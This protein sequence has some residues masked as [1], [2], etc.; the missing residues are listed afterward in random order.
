MRVFTDVLRDIQ[1]GSLVDELTEA[2]AEIVAH[3]K[4]TGKKGEIAI[5]LTVKKAKGHE[6]VMSLDAD[7]K[8]KVPAFER[9]STT[10]FATQANALVSEN[11][12]QKKLAFKDVKNPAGTVREITDPATGEVRQVA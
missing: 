9:P 10:F 12:E 8:A 5:K 4:A 7:Y 1:G 6:T 3:V 2:L 11:P